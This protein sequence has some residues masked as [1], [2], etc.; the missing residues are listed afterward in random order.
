MIFIN[1]LP[2]M[3][4]IQVPGAAVDRRSVSCNAGADRRARRL[5]VRDWSVPVQPS[6]IEHCV[7]AS[8][9][10]FHLMIPYIHIIVGPLESLFMANIIVCIVASCG[11]IDF[12]RKGVWYL[13]GRHVHICLFY[14]GISSSK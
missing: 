9:R 12:S 14:T 3:S 2:K 11:T 4:N 6:G 5:Y 7:L 1:L 8:L 10:M 13:N